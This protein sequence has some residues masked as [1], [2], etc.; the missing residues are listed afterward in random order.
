MK[1]RSLRTQN[2]HGYLSL[3]VKFFTDLT[4]LIGINGSGK[5]SAV[6]ALMALLTPAMRDLAHMQFEELAVTIE[7]DGNIVTVRAT[8]SE[9]ELR[10]YVGDEGNPLIVPIFAQEPFE[11]QP[12]FDERELDYYREHETMHAKHTVLRRLASIPTP[13]FLDLER[14]A[15]VGIR[16]RRGFEGAA[17]HLAHPPTLSRGSLQNSLVDAHF[18]AEAEYRRIQAKQRELADALKQDLI[19]SWFAVPTDDSGSFLTRSRQFGKEVEKHRELV[20]NVLAAI[21]IPAE[22]IAHDVEP[23]FTNVRNIVQRL[24][25]KGN[26]A[27]LLSA[28]QTLFTQWFAMQPQL[29]R[30]TKVVE[31]VEQY[32]K[33]FAA[34]FAP[35]QRYLDVVNQFLVDSGKALAFSPTG[36]LQLALHSRDERRPITA[37]SSGERQLVVILTH[38][39]FNP[40]AR[41][42][43]LLI[44]D[45][46]ELSLHVKWQE[47]FVSA[48]RGASE[49]LQ[50]ILATHSPSIIVDRVDRCVDVLAA[51]K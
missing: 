50:L 1:I 31:R 11:S 5:T 28:D 9:S 39:A 15:Q 38:L 16:R 26:V 33:H 51:A 21:G 29:T 43:N 34:T 41:D 48:L 3:Q 46:P 23:F 6:R 20:Y 17:R 42:A 12:H 35:I 13:M 18:L 14:R 7:N 36:N 47:M 40:A 22:A 49:G 2:L 30:I 44:I 10:L 19:L 45:E 8:R 27:D 4:F 25:S 24:P 37:L 32:N